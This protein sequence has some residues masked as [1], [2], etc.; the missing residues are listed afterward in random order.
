MSKVQERNE[1]R[2]GE[3]SHGRGG[4]AEATRGEELHDSPMMVHLLEALR[5]GTDIGHF[6]RLTFAMVARHFMPEEELVK[7]L[8]KQ[9][10]QDQQ[11][12]RALVLQVQRKGYN[13]PKRERI[14][15]WQAQQEFPICPDGDD[16]QAC[17]VYR[18]LKLPEQVYAQ[19]QE[20]WEERAEAEE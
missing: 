19:I 15:E 4:A 7:L 5:A 20:F 9:P 16:P 6:G 8:A 3:T 12:A 18:E 13:P 2:T 11:K 10:D 14:L 1:R 17:N